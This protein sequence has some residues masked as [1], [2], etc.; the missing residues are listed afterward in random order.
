MTDKSPSP[1]PKGLKVIDGDPVSMS[2][3]IRERENNSEPKGQCKH[4][5]VDFNRLRHDTPIFEIGCYQCHK[6]WKT[7][8]SFIKEIRQPL[9]KEIEAL[10]NHNDTMFRLARDRRIKIAELERI[11]KA[12]SESCKDFI[13]KIRIADK[14]VSDL[15]RQLSTVEHDTA[16]KIYSYVEKITWTKNGVKTTDGQAVLDFIKQKFLKGADK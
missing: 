2:K 10:K 6:I 1:E 8:N 16:G 7:I 3:F 13:S 5:D 11:N 12:F 15:K 14:E 4:E 9:L